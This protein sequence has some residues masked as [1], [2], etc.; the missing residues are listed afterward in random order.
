MFTKEYLKL[1]RENEKLIGQD[2]VL[3]KKILVDKD[4]H[5]TLKE[6]LKKFKTHQ[7]QGFIYDR[8]I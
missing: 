5:L 6:M 4:E 1:Q 2:P 8:E 7:R 3:W